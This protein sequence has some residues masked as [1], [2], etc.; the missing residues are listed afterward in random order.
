VN[1]SFPS[2]PEVS[3]PTPQQQQQQRGGAGSGPYSAP[4]A[5]P[6]ASPPLVVDAHIVGVEAQVVP[7]V[8]QP[9]APPATRPHAQWDGS[10]GGGPNNA[11]DALEQQQQQKQQPHDPPTGDEPDYDALLSSVLSDLATGSAAAAPAGE[12]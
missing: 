4:A 9:Q 11:Q 7:H 5:A 10:G 12:S 2:V 8:Q 6:A 3:E 1:R